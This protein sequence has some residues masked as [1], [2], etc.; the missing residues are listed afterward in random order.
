MTDDGYAVRLAHAREV[1]LL[2]EVERR[3]SVVFEDWL[4]QTGLTPTILERVSS[5]DELTQAQSRGHLWVALARVRE[6][7]RDGAS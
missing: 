6:E 3:A 2:P 5:I 1:A 7:E 4:D